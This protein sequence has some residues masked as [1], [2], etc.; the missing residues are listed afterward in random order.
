M[1]VPPGRRMVLIFACI[2]A[3]AG[4]YIFQREIHGW[5]K[6]FELS[7]FSAFAIGRSI[8]FFTNNLLVI[9]LIY[10][11][12]GKK[13]YVVFSMYILIIAIVFI[14][15]PYI[16]I[17]SYTTYNG[18]LISFLHRLLVNPLLMLLLIPA[19]LLQ[20]NYSNRDNQKNTRI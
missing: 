1:R 20:E 17:K 18:P 19:F 7:D 10:G 6:V 11:V 16:I 8:R 13:K 2:T 15:V 12:F 5:L 4:S 9:L 14:L 3:L